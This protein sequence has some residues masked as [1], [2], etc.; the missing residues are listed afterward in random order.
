M[1][2][3]SVFPRALERNKSIFAAGCFKKETIKQQR[4]KTDLVNWKNTQ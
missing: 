4:A 3:D 2:V 1:W